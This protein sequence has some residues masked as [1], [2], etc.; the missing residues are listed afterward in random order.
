MHY[1]RKLLYI[2]M[3]LWAKTYFLWENSQGLMGICTIF[4]LLYN[5]FFSFSFFFK[6]FLCELEI[7]L[8][9]FREHSFAAKVSGW[10]AHIGLMCV[11]WVHVKGGRGSDFAF[12][13]L[14][15]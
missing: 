15:C 5:A 14:G 7:S 11:L 12:D 9:T 2:D 4:L 3:N 13:G 10:N 1:R 6:S 8:E